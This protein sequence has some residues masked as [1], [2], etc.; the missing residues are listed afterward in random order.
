MPRLALHRVSLARYLRGERIS[1]LY[2]A[3]YIGAADSSSGPEA[4]ASSQSAPTFYCSQSYHIVSSGAGRRHPIRMVS[5]PHFVF[6]LSIRGGGPP[7]VGSLPSGV[8]G[9]LLGQMHLFCCSLPGRNRF[10]SFRF[11]LDKSLF[12]FSLVWQLLFFRFDAVRFG[13]LFLP[14][15]QLE[16]RASCAT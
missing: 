2:T 12:R 3:L 9:R 8:S 1:T 15:M 14:V 5:L 10:C 4:H 11:V 13:F 7:S 6:V 16:P